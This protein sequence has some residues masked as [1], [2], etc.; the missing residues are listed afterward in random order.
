MGRPPL[1]LGV[2]QS[3]RQR[4]EMG[5]W[6]PG[7]RLPSEE[8]LS[9]ELFV[10]RVTVREAL[11]VLELEGVIRRRHGVGSFVQQVPNRAAGELQK[12]EPFVASIRRAGLPATEE[13]VSLVEVSLP[14]SVARSLGLAPGSSGYRLEMLRRLDT[15]PVIY[16]Q[17]FVRGDLLDPDEFRR[18]G[19]NI[20]DYL[21]ATGRPQVAYA[22]LTVDAVLPD[23]HEQEVLACGPVEPLVR[24]R[25][26]A[27]AN[28]HKPLYQTCFLIRSKFYPLRLVRQ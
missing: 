21:A 11:R 13:L 25:G 15:T 26:I 4:I 9:R 17:D 5:L 12:L 14:A 6:Q 16:S 19:R 3:I 8:A 10:S 23:P 28:D 2:A 27:Y 20:L 22:P 24:L 7:D 1:Y 18:M